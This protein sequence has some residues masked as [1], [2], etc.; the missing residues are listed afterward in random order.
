MG[1]SPETSREQ[2]REKCLAIG[3]G[4]D[5]DAISQIQAA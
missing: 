2:P 4:N 3:H 5:F 1:K